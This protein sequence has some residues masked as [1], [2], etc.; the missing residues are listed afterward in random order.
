MARLIIIMIIALV[1]GAW[2]VCYPSYLATHDGNCNINTITRP[3]HQYPDNNNI[4]PRQDDADTTQC[5][6]AIPVARVAPRLSLLLNLLANISTV[7]LCQLSM[8]GYLLY[9]NNCGPGSLKKS[10]SLSSVMNS[11]FVTFPSCL[12]RPLGTA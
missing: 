10:S 6:S 3:R 11:C 5:N 2:A 7:R 8:V 9:L 1:P 4:I 12:G